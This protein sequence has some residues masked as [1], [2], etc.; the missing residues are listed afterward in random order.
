MFWEVIE[1]VVFISSGIVH[2]NSGVAAGQACRAWGVSGLYCMACTVWP[3]LYGL[4][5]MVC[6][7]GAWGSQVLNGVFV[8]FVVW[9]PSH[10]LA[11]CL[12]F[13]GLALWREA[14]QRRPACASGPSV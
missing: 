12:L 5:C 10:L 4:Y 14:F 9:A 8:R 3:V 2:S 6:S 11:L 7:D 13:A 1:L